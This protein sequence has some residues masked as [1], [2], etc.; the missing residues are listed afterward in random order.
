MKK[1]VVFGA[2]SSSKSINKKLSIYA[3]AQF[4]DHEII[5]L[6]LN[7]YEMPIYS[8]DKEIKIGIPN[9]AHNFYSTLKYS[10]GI[11]ISFA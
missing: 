8:E 9:Q 7:D 10:D 11:I 5:I 2:S 6:D 3:A 1:I 4:K